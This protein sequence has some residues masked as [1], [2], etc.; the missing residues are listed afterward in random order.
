[1]SNNN[2]TQESIQLLIRR[3]DQLESNV[4]NKLHIIIRS[5][6]EM[7]YIGKRV[8]ELQLGLCELQEKAKKLCRRTNLVGEKAFEHEYDDILWQL[9]NTLKDAERVVIEHK[10]GLFGKVKHKTYAAI[11]RSLGMPPEKVGKIYCGALKKLRDP[12][13]RSMVYVIH[14]SKLKEEILSRCCAEENKCP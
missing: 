14:H 12:S 11:G 5:I 13:R 9:L 8:K 7:E 4:I 6:S 1:M 2:G 3:F 10:H